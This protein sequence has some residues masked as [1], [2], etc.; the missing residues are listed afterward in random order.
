MLSSCFCHPCSLFVVNIDCARAL[1]SCILSNLPLFHRDHAVWERRE[2]K[3]ALLTA[4]GLQFAYQ[5]LELGHGDLNLLIQSRYVGVV[6]GI[7]KVGEVERHGFCI[8]GV[9]IAIM[10]TR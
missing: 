7:G 9:A 3:L 4:D 2:L 10:V 8:D 1:S 6:V 5:A